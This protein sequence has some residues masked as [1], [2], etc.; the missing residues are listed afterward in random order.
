MKLK[1]LEMPLNYQEKSDA[2][3]L[4]KYFTR[5]SVK[6]GRHITKQDIEKYLKK[7]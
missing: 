6:I 5:Y 1:R 7:P 3:K 2:K 4:M